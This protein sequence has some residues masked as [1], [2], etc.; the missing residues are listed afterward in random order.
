MTSPVSLFCDECGAANGMQA[1][2]CFA[3]NQPLNPSFLAPTIQA[4]IT[5]VASM[6]FAP[7][8]TSTAEPLRSGTVLAR[9]YRIEEEIGQGGFGIVYKA[10]DIHW[11]RRVAIKQ[12]NLHASPWAF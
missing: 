8:S 7:I 2:V 4:P 9:R 10:R 11:N 5:P 12:I 1:I 3:C 6:A